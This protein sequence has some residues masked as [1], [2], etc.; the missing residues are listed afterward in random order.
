MGPSG[1]WSDELVCQALSEREP[2]QNLGPAAQEEPGGGLAAFSR[3]SARVENGAARPEEYGC[4]VKGPL[5]V[6]RAQGVRLRFCVLL[7][8]ARKARTKYA[9]IRQAQYGWEN[10]R[11]RRARESRGRRP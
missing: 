9:Y 1:G 2:Q 6:V 10:V 5:G 3:L 4:A 8:V 11:R 7:K